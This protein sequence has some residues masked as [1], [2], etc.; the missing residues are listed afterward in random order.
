MTVINNTDIITR[1]EFIQLNFENKLKTVWKTGNFV[2]AHITS[3]GESHIINLYQVNEFHV[4]VV[5]T[6]IGTKL[7]KINC[8]QLGY[9]MESF[10]P[11]ETNY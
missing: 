9:D 4:E 10:F 11:T 1:D 7:K 3:V 2:D 5:Y 6:E 8:Y